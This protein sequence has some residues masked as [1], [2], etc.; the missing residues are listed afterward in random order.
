MECV[1]IVQGIVHDVM[2]TNQK[3]VCLEFMSN[4][5]VQDVNKN[6]KPAIN[7]KMVKNAPHVYQII[8]YEKRL[9][10][11]LNVLGKV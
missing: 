9:V 4:L 1:K 8:I 11:L 5:N 7:H 2:A 6:A 10:M 3:N